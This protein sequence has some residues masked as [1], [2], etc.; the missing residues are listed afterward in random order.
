MATIARRGSAGSPGLNGSV[1]GC[2]STDDFPQFV[3]LDIFLEA[4]ER[5]V[6][7]ELLEAGDVHALRDAARD[8]SAPQ[9]VAG[10]GRDVEPGEAGPM[11]DDQCDRI[12]VDRLVIFPNSVERLFKVSATSTAPNSLEFHARSI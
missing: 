2:L 9:A 5:G 10:K 3:E 11:L 8:G 7:G 12:G 1:R 6:A 4:F